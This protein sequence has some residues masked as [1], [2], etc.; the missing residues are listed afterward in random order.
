MTNLAARQVVFWFTDW[1]NSF[2]LV[3][4]GSEVQMRAGC[5]AEIRSATILLQMMEPWVVVCLFGPKCNASCTSFGMA[6]SHV[7]PRGNVLSERKR[8][9][10][11]RLK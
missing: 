1:N 6:L 8:A 10:A 5:A 11:E 2:S 3:R 7:S 9:G 4:N